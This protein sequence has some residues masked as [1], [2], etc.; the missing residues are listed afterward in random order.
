METVDHSLSRLV[1]VGVRV[2][3]GGGLAW[4]GLLC[5]GNDFHADTA[6]WVT[7][8]WTVWRRGEGE[9]NPTPEG[10]FRSLA[11]LPTNT[12]AFLFGPHVIGL[13]I[14]TE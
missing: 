3:L 14:V 10:L 1:G 6:R 5:L 7:A 4:P 2:K 9:V 12:K 11:P 8:T 13:V